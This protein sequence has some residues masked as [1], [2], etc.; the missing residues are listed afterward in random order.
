L[1]LDG[2]STNAC[3]VAVSVATTCEKARPLEMTEGIDVVV[4]TP[5]AA[6][7]IVP[8]GVTVTVAVTSQSPGVSVTFVMGVAL[9]GTKTPLAALETYS[10][11]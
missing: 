10:P 11:T 4:L 5:P 3:S 2:I 6:D 9:P 8:V 1:N 7:W